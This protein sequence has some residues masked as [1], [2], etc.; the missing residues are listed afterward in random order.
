MDE[1][2]VYCCLTSAPRGWEDL[3]DRI[4]GVVFHVVDHTAAARQVIL[5]PTQRDAI[6]ADVFAAL[7][8]DNCRLLR[9]YRGRSR[10]TTYIVVVARRIVIRLLMNHTAS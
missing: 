4:L 9:Q 2:I 7:R 1:E 10:L 5:S 8:H 3:V 6:S